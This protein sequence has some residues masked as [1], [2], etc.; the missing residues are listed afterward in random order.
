MS[1]LKQRP[2]NMR[3]GLLIFS[4]VPIS[5]IMCI[6]VILISNSQ[7]QK[8]SSTAENKFTRATQ[9]INAIVDRAVNFS[10]NVIANP[11]IADL[12]KKRYSNVDE[13]FKAATTLNMFFTNYYEKV[14]TEPSITIYHSNSSMYQS[15]FSK[16]IKNLDA[17]LVNILKKQ[18]TTNILWTETK[19]DFNAYKA[20]NENDFIL[21]TE[22][23]ISKEDIK[24]ILKRFDVY[25]NDKYNKKNKIQ[26]TK[27]PIEN[28]FTICRPLGNERYINLFFPKGIKNTIYTRNFVI[29]LTIYALI[30]LIIIISS[31]F[32]SNYQKEKLTDFIDGL[33][34]NSDLSELAHM[35]LDSKDVLFPVYRKILQLITDV[36]D[37][38]EKTNRIA[39]EKN[40]I[41]L[42]YT[43]SQFNPH[44]L[45][46]TLG[47][48]KWKCFKQDPILATTIDSMVDYYRACISSHDE[49]VS[50]DEEISLVEKYIR[51][52]EFTHE[53]DYK[54]EFD[55]EDKIKNFKT[56]KHLLQPFVENAILHGIQ[57]IPDGYIKICAK[58]IDEN[59]VITIS[60]NGMGISEENLKAIHEENYFSKYKS[61]G[62]KN[63]RARI[64][65]F[66]GPNSG[67]DIESN[68]GKGTKVTISLPYSE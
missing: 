44:L 59:V 4:L 9:E 27:N 29:L 37:L 19:T 45:Y 57:Q 16:H 2:F 3:K 54:Y 18:P 53:Q 33:D 35:S 26:L 20:Y 51:L 36:N 10:N 38:N 55:I 65:F 64:G 13:N 5:I 14:N 12:F 1:I 30:A 24:S 68:E 50:L 62:I 63:T 31:G 34:V 46:N 43:Q 67:I 28:Q 11:D 22:Y 40:M 48:F 60:D 42:K 52:I 23:K 61:Y 66:H 49:I 6:V 25:T 7:I 8:I 17:S 58:T 41:E 21:I 56:I 39:H 32:F 47:V 15:M